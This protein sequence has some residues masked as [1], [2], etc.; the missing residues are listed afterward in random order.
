M[1][2]SA[3]S[4]VPDDLAGFDEEEN[5]VR[6]T[7]VFKPPVEVLPKTKR[8]EELQ[9]KK[10]E[11]LRKKKEAAETLR[12][13]KEKAEAQ[14]RQ[15]E[16]QAKKQKALIEQQRRE[17]ERKRREEIEQR[18]KMEGGLDQILDAL[19][20]DASAP[21]ITVCGIDLNSARVRLLASALSENTSCQSIDL[22]RK[23]LC[24][25]DGVSLAGML[26]QNKA[27]QKLECEGNN[28]GVKAAQAIGEALKKNTS[29]R[30]LNMESNNL[31]AGGNDQKGIIKLA[32]ALHENTSLRVLMLS[33]NGITAQAGE[34]F[35]K[36]IE[37]NES[38]TLV[39][40]SGNDASP[41][42]E[43]L[44]RIDD[45]VQRNRERQSTIRRAERRERFA[46]YNEEF[47]CRQHSMQV[48]AMRLEIEALQE[49]R[50]NRAKAR[51]E[52]W[53][54]E[55]LEMEVEEKQ[56]Q[57]ELN[58]EALLRAEAKAKGKKKRK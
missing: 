20:K 30:S 38:L 23:G 25:E 19:T 52:R 8:T 33:K 42:V 44:R 35:V 37:A 17:A 48:E 29:I 50:M 5:E 18:K 11:D 16:Q 40:L 58:E 3:S 26:E 51:G 54:D 57:E 43:Q 14:R 56:K 24:D 10:V 55:K 49:R 12:K 21:D 4:P 9:K 28:L 36:A 46:L 7:L 2:T 53:V 41:S 39:D 45:V 1:A 22:N 27:L 15:R 32:E 47:K 13:E 34:Y 31:T 6:G